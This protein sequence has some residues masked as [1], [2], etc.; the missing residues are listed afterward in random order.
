M[1]VVDSKMPPAPSSE[2]LVQFFELTKQYKITP[3]WQS[4]VDTLTLKVNAID[5]N[6]VNVS[7]LASAGIANRNPDGSWNTINATT[8]GAAFLVIPDPSAVRYIRINADN[9]ISLVT[10]PSIT[11]SR[12]GNAA[13]ADLLTQLDS[14]GLI[15][16]NT[17]A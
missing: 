6:L 5:A 3:A 12:G 13:L 1:A 11:G 14:I 15:N 10:P 16:D 8:V 4:W 2:S 7:N 9:S 17:T